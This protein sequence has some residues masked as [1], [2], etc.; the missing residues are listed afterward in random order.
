MHYAD[1]AK[2]LKRR[3]ALNGRL[4]IMPTEAGM[5]SDPSPAQAADIITRRKL[6]EYTWSTSFHPSFIRDLTFEGFLCISSE[7]AGSSN[8]PLYVLVPKLHHMRCVIDLSQNKLHISKNIRKQSKK[9]WITFNRDFEQVVLGCIEQHGENWLYPPMR[10]ALKDLRRD[11]KSGGSLE[12]TT[13]RALSIEI[14]RGDFNDEA[15]WEL[16]AGEL[17]I[18]YGSVYLSLTGYYNHA[19]SGAGSVQLGALGAALKEAGVLLWDMGQGQGTEYKYDYG[20]VDVPRAD[21]LQLQRAHRNN[22]FW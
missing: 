17:G 5:P 6:S 3:R 1:V 18:A 13:F 7:L 10:C 15:S 9:Y 4:L 2:Y 14:W 16:V 22:D 11:C 21:F 20:A 19:V 8:S 12:P